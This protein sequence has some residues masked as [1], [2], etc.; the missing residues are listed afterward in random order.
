LIPK[1]NWIECLAISVFFL[2]LSVAGA[3]WDFTSGLLF[4]GI[5]GIM[6]LAVCLV[7]AGIFGLMLLVHLQQGGILPSFGH[8]KKAA[9]PAPTA[10][11]APAAVPAAAPAKAAQPQRTVQ[12]K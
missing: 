9:A 1:R 11:T 7:M 8:K 10:K 6:L 3:V 4:S 12:A 2:F 5:D